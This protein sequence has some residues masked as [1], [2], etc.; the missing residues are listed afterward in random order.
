MRVR[1]ASLVLL[2]LAAAA[3]SNADE[4]ESPDRGPLVPDDR[5]R[6]AG[7][8]VLR[9]D[10]PFSTG[11]AV[12]LAVEDV[13]GGPARLARTWDLGDP[14]W[15]ADRDGARLYFALDARD[16]WPESEIAVRETMEIAARFDPDGNPAT[17]E[18]GVVRARVRVRAGDAGL[19]VELDLG[20]P[21]A[22]H[23]TPGG[24]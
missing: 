23:R 9:G 20:R 3:C 19:V 21:L 8:L 7:E 12:T 24:G 11:A 6:F 2:V 15:R 16:A 10:L 5:V 17:D 4:A 18:P 14:V 1:P 22:V 13:G